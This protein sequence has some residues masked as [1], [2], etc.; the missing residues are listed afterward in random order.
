MRRTTLGPLTGG[1][2]LNSSA[3]DTSA[4]SLGDGPKGG[5]RASLSTSF[6]KYGG[7]RGENDSARA[8]QAPGTGG[9]G[10]PSTALGGGGGRPSIAT[11]GVGVEQ[12]CGTRR[13]AAVACFT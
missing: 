6:T 10:R 3:L 12:R 1:D 13:L 7:G 5:G 11:A 4:L 8:K 9:K 2:L